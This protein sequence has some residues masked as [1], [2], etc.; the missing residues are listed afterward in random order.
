M[1][2][3]LIDLDEVCAGLLEYSTNLYNLDNGTNLDWRVFDDWHGNGEMLKQYFTAEGTFL[4]LPVI[5]DSQAVLKDLADYYDIYF[6]T[7]APTPHS[8]MEKK[9]WVDEHFPFIGQKKTIITHHKYLL[10]GGDL[11]LDD[12]PV[13]LSK[14]PNIRVCMDMP[15]NQHTECEHRVK[16][17]KS[18]A[19]LI[20]NLEYRGHLN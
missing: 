17:W 20:E 2:V 9:I 15:Y 1:A 12:S 8:A 11:L 18:F 16:D 19:T 7:A 5:K 3:L 14:F 10:S 6:V 13:Y 4:R